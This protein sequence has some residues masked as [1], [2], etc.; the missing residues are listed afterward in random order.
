MKANDD[1]L[2]VLLLKDNGPW[3]VI[4][5]QHD[6]VA[7]GE[8]PTK[9]LEAFNWTYWTQVL[10]DRKKGIEPLSQVEPAPQE[11]W[12]RFDQGLP[13]ATQFELQPPFSLDDVPSVPED[14]RL[15]A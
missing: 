9:A 8:S 2:K 4:C 12:V 13:F 10:L 6:I 14:V 3:I 11:Y 15:A 5:L 1:R 7:Q